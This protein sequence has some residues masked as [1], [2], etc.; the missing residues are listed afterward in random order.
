MCGASID[1]TIL[2]SVPCMTKPKAAF[3]TTSTRVKDELSVHDRN[4]YMP[5]AAGWLRGSP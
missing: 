4:N 5:V 1:F 3:F 2:W